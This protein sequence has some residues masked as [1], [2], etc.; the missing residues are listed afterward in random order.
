LSRQK[1]TANKIHRL[2]ETGSVAVHVP[3]TSICPNGIK[4][5]G[6]VISREKM[7]NFAISFF[8]ILSPI[9]QDKKC[10]SSNTVRKSRI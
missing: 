9:K 10:A 7:V 5:V 8:F 3:P 2:D 1:F 4:Q 6:S